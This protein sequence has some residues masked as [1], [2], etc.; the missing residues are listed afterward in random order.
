MLK[1]QEYI[2]V[3][4]GMRLC[5]ILYYANSIK[6]ACLCHVDSTIRAEISSKPEVDN[7]G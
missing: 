2:L 6:H 4:L 7:E 5:H 3:C 1:V